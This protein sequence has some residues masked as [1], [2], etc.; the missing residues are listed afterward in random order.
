MSCSRFYQLQCSN[1]VQ[2]IL[3]RIARVYLRVGINANALTVLGMLVGVCA[4]LLVAAGDVQGAGDG[5]GQVAGLQRL[6]KQSMDRRAPRR[7]SIGSDRRN[8][9]RL[10]DPVPAYLQR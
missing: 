3:D 9:T 1:I 4:A 2:P 7:N 10:L 8:H 6:F 5:L